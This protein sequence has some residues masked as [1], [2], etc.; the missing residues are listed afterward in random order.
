MFTSPAWAQTIS[1][2]SGVREDTLEQLGAH[3]ALIVDR[4]DEL[5][6]ATDPEQPQRAGQ[7]H[8]ALLPDDDAER[9][10]AGEALLAEVVA[11]PLVHGL[12]RGRE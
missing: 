4:H 2:L 5:L 6:G 8:V 10:R 11:D 3:P 7:R 12:T 9:R 1:R